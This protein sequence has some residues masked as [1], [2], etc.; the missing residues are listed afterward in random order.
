[1]TGNTDSEQDPLSKIR[2]LD[3]LPR[4]ERLYGSILESIIS[5]CLIDPPSHLTKTNFWMNFVTKLCIICSNFFIDRNFQKKIATTRLWVLWHI[6]WEKAKKGLKLHIP[7]ISNESKLYVSCVLF[8]SSVPPKG[9]ENRRSIIYIC[10]VTN[11]SSASH[12]YTSDRYYN[13]RGCM[14]SID[15]V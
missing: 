12:W 2:E 8:I 7:G 6:M 11:L 3:E 14:Q 10:R 15:R 1:M 9:S 5:A 4:P 13:L